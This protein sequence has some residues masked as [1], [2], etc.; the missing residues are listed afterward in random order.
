MIAS[1]AAIVAEYSTDRRRA[2]AISFSMAGYPIGAI[3]GGIVTVY[4]LEAFDWQTVFIFGGVVTGLMIP[5]A[6][7]FLP[8]SIEHLLTRR[9]EDTLTRVNRVLVRMKKAP[10]ES[11][12][13]TDGKPVAV[14]SPVTELFASTLRKQT[15]LIWACF[16]LTMSSLYFAQTWTPKIMVDAGFDVSEGVTIGVLIQVGALIGIL[17]IGLLT[18]K[19]SIYATAAILMGFGF[20]AMLA[21]SFTLEQVE[22][23]YVLAVCI[24]LGVNAAVIALYAIVL[25]VYPVD[26]RVTG[27][28]WAIGVGRFSAILTPAIAGLLLGAG[29]ELTML[30]CLFAVPMLLAVGSVLAIR[31]RRFP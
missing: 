9:A 6:L 19:R 31:S 21:F 11:L 29:I 27:I 4:L 7:V 18:A 30:Y 1:L 23:L 20:V 13:E 15:V 12:P 25:E 17:I 3:F 8:E 26:I 28:G 2:A 5:L 10:L 22:F 16:F 24:G 14:T